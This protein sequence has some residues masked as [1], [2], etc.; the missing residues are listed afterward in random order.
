MQ[1]ILVDMHHLR[2][3]NHRS[4]NVDGLLSNSQPLQSRQSNTKIEFDQVG[5]DFDEHEVDE[6][7]NWT[8]N[9]G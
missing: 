8:K 6:L 1:F 3:R 7:L 5:G 9:I 4:K 2:H